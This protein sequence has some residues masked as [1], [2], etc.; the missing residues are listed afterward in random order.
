[1]AEVD[2]TLA[3]SDREIREA[4]VKKLERSTVPARKKKGDLLRRVLDYRAEH[5][6][7]PQPRTD[8]GEWASYD[9]YAED[10]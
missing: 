6:V 7:G 1:M 5:Q 3:E 4:D 8:S 10:D 2:V 9:E